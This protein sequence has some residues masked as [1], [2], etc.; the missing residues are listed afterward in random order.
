MCRKFVSVTAIIE[1]E[2]ELPGLTRA[3]MKIPQLGSLLPLNRI[4]MVSEA[5]LYDN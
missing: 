3:V 2:Q 1:N 5:W 4:F